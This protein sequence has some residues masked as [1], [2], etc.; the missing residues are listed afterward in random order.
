MRKEKIKTGERKSREETKRE[1]EERRKA[2]RE[3]EKEAKA[4]PVRWKNG[5]E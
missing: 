1:G 3:G 2:G 5:K 4:I